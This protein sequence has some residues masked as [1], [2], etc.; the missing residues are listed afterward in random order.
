M[1]VSSAG[2]V[3]GTAQIDLSVDTTVDLTGDA[4]VHMKLSLSLAIC[5]KF[6]GEESSFYEYIRI[7][8]SFTPHN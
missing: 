3:V 4:C 2:V 8:V 5:C 7:P 6:Q 1:C